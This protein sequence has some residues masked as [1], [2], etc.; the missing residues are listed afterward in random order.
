MSN[1]NYSIDGLNDLLND[2]QNLSVFLST[3][4]SW[5]PAAQ[6]EPLR[7]SQ[8]ELIERASAYALILSKSS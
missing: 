6:L 7:A 2:L 1:T 8:L 3:D 5:L 4:P